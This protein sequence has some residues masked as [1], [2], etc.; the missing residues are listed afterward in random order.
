M[1]QVARFLVG[2]GATA[3]LLYLA[4]PPMNQGYLAGVALVPVLFGIR[5]TRFAV[6]FVA[7]IF[8]ALLLSLFAAAGLHNSSTH[9]GSSAAWIYTGFT[10]FGLVL[11]FGLGVFAQ[12]KE[13]SNRT[14]IT[15]PAW[16]VLFEAASLVGLPMHLGLTQHQAIVPLLLASTGG[17]WLVSFLVWAVN[18][19]CV[20]FLEALPD[21]PHN[22]ARH[23]LGVVIPLALFAIPAP[24]AQDHARGL[25]VAV[26][27]T[28]S[29]DEIEIAALHARASKVADLVIWPELAGNAFA[30]GGDVSML[31]DLSSKGAFVTSFTDHSTPLPFNTAVLFSAGAEQPKR[32]HKRKP[33]A[34]EV[35]I[36]QAGRSATKTS[37]NSVEVGLNICFDSCFPAVLRDTA[38]L[39]DVTL[40]ALPTLDP[41]TPFGVIQAIHAAYTPFRC[42][43]L[44]VPI[45]RTDTTSYSA[46]YIPFT[47]P[48]F[49][50]SQYPDAAIKT[51]SVLPRRIPT[52]YWL[53]GDWF[54]YACG[55]FVVLGWRV[56]R[57]PNAEFTVAMEAPTPS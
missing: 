9:L 41:D 29:P 54:L 40:I 53:L 47:R 23:S 51:F 13:L 7:G 44:G 39:K 49:A 20:R 52:A 24:L 16:A 26:L 50:S 35:N 19:G 27:Q 21:K 25:K 8:I 11:G 36:H 18:M 10:L 28:D 57:R 4:L 15:V 37:W 43:E 46:A 14:L 33:F 45:I 48:Q 3:W 12:T 22:L 2:V 17:I 6:G 38:R 42:A 30:P 55:A 1:K 31:A 34:G 5:R 32:Y 56:S